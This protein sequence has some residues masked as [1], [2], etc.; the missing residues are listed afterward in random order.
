MTTL[1]F[2]L[3]LLP[4]V[5]GLPY[6]FTNSMEISYADATDLDKQQKVT[7]KK[8]QDFLTAKGIDTSTNYEPQWN[9]NG[10][11]SYADSEHDKSLIMTNIEGN[12]NVVEKNQDFPS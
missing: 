8:F 12:G 5:V 6:E 10:F 9:P 7:V 4:L 1:F 11:D 2:Y 3:G